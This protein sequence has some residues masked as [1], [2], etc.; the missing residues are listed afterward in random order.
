MFMVILNRRRVG[1]IGLRVLAEGLDVYNVILSDKRVGGR[2]LMS[3]ALAAVVSYGRFLY[4]GL[5][6]RVKVLRGNPA[7]SW[8]GKNGFR[9]IA[10]ARDYVTMELRTAR[11]VG[12]FR[13]SL[14]LDIPFDNRL[15]A[16]MPREKPS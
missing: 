9:R 7:I 11:D 8:Y 1:C 4:P 16:R 15:P 12:P 13:C 14:R 6:T 10:V 5:P 3:Q 2:G